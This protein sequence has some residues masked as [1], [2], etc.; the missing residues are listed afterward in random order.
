M[1]DDANFAKQLS[2]LEMEETYRV[3]T[4]KTVPKME[5]FANWAMTGDG[6]WRMEGEREDGWGWSS[7][8]WC[9]AHRRTPHRSPP[10][11]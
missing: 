4:S 1:S 5:S 2:V 6:G 7:R 9:Q 3:V 11:M 8:L 10:V